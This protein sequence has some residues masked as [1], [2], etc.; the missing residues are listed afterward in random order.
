MKKEKGEEMP[1]QER[2][3]NFEECGIE[4]MSE[5]S[6][7]V[8]PQTE[9]LWVSK[10]RDIKDRLADIY[11]TDPDEFYRRKKL[12]EQA[13]KEREKGIQK[14]MPEL[15]LVEL[16]EVLKSTERLYR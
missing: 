8:L 14:T 13:I 9:H 12:I 16:R 3:E 5:E 1:M 4:E 10:L 2:D 11:R 6:A 15:S 7:K